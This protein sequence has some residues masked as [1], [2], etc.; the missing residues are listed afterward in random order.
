MRK[1]SGIC[2]YFVIASGTST[3]HVRAL[4]DNIIKT[5]RE[6]GQRLRHV[7]GERE[8]SW[9][10]IDFG[11]VVGHVFLKATR[12]FYDLEK[13]WRA[14]PQEMF[15]EPEHSTSGNKNNKSLAAKKRK[16]PKK[17]VKKPSRKVVKRIKKKARKKSK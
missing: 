2:D 13:L 3:T 4:S 16:S 7:E 17:S 5:L 6:K 15:K 12:K 8:A 14:A 10:L 11:D 9:I 1:I